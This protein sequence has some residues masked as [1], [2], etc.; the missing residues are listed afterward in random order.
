MKTTD[1]VGFWI[2]IASA[3]EAI[4]AS[5]C[6]EGSWIASSQVLLAMTSR[7]PPTISASRNDC[8]HTSAISPRTSRE[9]CQS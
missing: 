2:V 6:K 1:A 3:S 4:H 9:F 5:S 8:T 7:T